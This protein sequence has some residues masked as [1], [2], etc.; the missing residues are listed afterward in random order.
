MIVSGPKN[1]IEYVIDSILLAYNLE[2]KL[3]VK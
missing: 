2:Y 3:K 1:C